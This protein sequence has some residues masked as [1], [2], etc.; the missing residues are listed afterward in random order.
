MHSVLMRSE[1]SDSNFLEFGTLSQHQECSEPLVSKPDFHTQ[2]S[3]RTPGRH[4]CYDVYLS[5]DC[6]LLLLL[7]RFSR[8]QLSAT[9]QRADCTQVMVN[10]QISTDREQ[11]M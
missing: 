2:S 3:P 11:F 5:T 6:K 9:P 1:K 10:S 7:S 4:V 8:V